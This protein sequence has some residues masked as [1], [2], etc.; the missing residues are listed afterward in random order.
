MLV[1]EYQEVVLELIG[2]AEL[3]TEFTC[4]GGYIQSVERHL[5]NPLSATS[6]ASNR[7]EGNAKSF[8]NT[9]CGTTYTN[10]SVFASEW[11]YT[12]QKRPYGSS[13]WTSYSDTI[14]LTQGQSYT[15]LITY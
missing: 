14:A 13:S 12:Y 15:H 10:E 6:P 5:L 4:S 7:Y 11:V 8:Y 3:T 2:L 1:G 9:N